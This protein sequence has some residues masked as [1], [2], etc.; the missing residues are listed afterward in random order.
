MHQKLKRVIGRNA[1]CTVR[2]HVTSI[3]RSRTNN[4]IRTKKQSFHG[5]PLPEETCIAFS[6][7]QGRELF[8]KAL[9]EG[10]LKSYWKLAESFTTQSQPAAC[11]LAS[12]VMVLNALRVDPKKVWKGVWRWWDES[13]FYSHK[14][15]KDCKNCV[16]IKER[17]LEQGLTFEE[18]VGNAKCERLS[19]E[20]YF[21][22]NK[23]IVANSSIETKKLNHFREVLRHTQLTSSSNSSSDDVNN[24][25]L[26][27]SFS[28][29]V[30][31]QTGTGHF[32]PI[33]GYVPSM[34]KVL[35]MDVARFKY[36]SY[37]VD[38]ETLWNAMCQPDLETWKPRG[39]IVVSGDQTEFESATEKELLESTCDTA[40][41]CSS[42]N[43]TT[44]MTTTNT[45]SVLCY[46]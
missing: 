9:K 38:I 34:D 37:W 5:R 16:D 31:K 11:G 19:L 43:A 18:L 46:S 45:S 41:V 23:T 6:S 29:S 44:N 26:I 24:D 20:G 30:L 40:S 14:A 10:G 1:L 2:E 12:L 3:M 33:G 28:R 21:A 42:T 35:V 36:P 39:Y 4:T 7:D 15:D 17:N 13:L 27:C 22:S 25:M 32:S 8:A